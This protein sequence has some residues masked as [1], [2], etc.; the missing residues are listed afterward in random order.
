MTDGKDVL[1]AE[2][3]ESL[4]AAIISAY[5]NPELWESLRENGLALVDDLFGEGA[6]KARVNDLLATVADL[7]V[8]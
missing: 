2:T 7:S 3:P 8:V 6:S 4:A 1:L 5:Q